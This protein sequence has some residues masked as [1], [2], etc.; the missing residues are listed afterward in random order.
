MVMGCCANDMQFLGFACEY[1]GVS[2]NLKE[3]EWVL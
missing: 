1:D 3:K 2:K